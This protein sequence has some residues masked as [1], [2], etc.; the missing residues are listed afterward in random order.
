MWYLV[1]KKNTWQC[2]ELWETHSGRGTADG[3][4]A[5]PSGL[6]AISQ[7]SA[8]TAA[9]HCISIKASW[10]NNEE[11]SFPAQISNTPPAT[12]SSSCTRVCVWH[13]NYKYSLLEQAS[14]GH[15][16]IPK[17]GTGLGVPPTLGSFAPKASMSIG[18][19]RTNSFTKTSRKSPVLNPSENQGSFICYFQT[20]LMLVEIGFSVTASFDPFLGSFI[21]SVQSAPKFSTSPLTYWVSTLAI[22]YSLFLAEQFLSESKSL[23][24][25]S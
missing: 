13:W 18:W 5:H 12:R 8:E 6:S 3:D 7:G 16:A 11:T 19:P 15:L 9:L 24:F 14:A 17:W 10:D 20:V 4:R 23:F 2:T 1:V 25:F 22:T 21:L